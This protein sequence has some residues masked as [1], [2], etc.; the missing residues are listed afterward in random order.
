MYHHKVS[1]TKA[2]APTQKQTVSN[3]VKLINLHFKKKKQ[4]Q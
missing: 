1:K 3:N 2:T 4:L